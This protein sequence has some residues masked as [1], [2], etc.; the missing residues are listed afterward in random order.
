MGLGADH[1]VSGF[2]VYGSVYL[3]SVSRSRVSAAILNSGNSSEKVLEVAFK[4]MLLSGTT[5][6]TVSWSS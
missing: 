5:L 3:G 6:S 4:V 2:L 1:V